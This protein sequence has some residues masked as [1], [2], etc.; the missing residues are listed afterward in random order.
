MGVDGSRVG[1]ENRRGPEE[2]KRNMGL[3]RKVEKWCLAR[4]VIKDKI[5]SAI[6]NFS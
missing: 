2:A 1:G 4:R 6:I 5:G 3:R